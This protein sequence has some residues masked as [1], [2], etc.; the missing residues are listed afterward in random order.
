MDGCDTR[1]H[2]S[3]EHST[4]RRTLSLPFVTLI[5]LL[6]GVVALGAA[7]PGAT[8]ATRM[9]NNRQANIPHSNGPAVADNGVL[10]EWTL[11]DDGSW[12]F[13]TKWDDFRSVLWFSEGNPANTTID[14]IGQLDPAAG[15]LREWAD[16]STGG[17]VHGLTLDRSHNFWF[18]EVE[19]GK[20]GMLQPGTNSFTEWSLDPSGEPHGILVDDVISGSVTIWLGER[21]GNAISSLEPATGRYVRHFDPL[22][23]AQPHGVVLAPDHSIWFVETCGNRVGQL[24]PG[25]TDTWR[26]WQP[27]T[28][29][30][31]CSPPNHIGPLFGT[32]VGNDFWYSEPY[33]GNLIRLNPSTNTFSI[34]P[35]PN[36]TPGADQITQV[37]ADPAGNILFTEM[38]SNMVGR[39]EPSGPSVPTVVVVAPTVIEGTPPAEATAPSAVVAETPV[40]RQLTPATRVV[41]GART[42]S[43]VEWPLPTPPPTPGRQ[44]GPAR[45]EYG[46]GSLWMSEVTANKVAS[47]AVFTDTPTASPTAMATATST[48]AATNTHFAPSSTPTAPAQT[49]STATA[50]A[51]TLNFIDVPVGSTFYPYVHCLACVGIINGYPDGTFKPNNQVTRGQLSKIVSN[52]AGFSDPQTTQMFHDVPV[53]STFQVFIG[54][55]ASRGYINGYPCGGPGEPCQPGNLP[56]FRPN[57]NATRG[58]IS[59]IDSNAAGFSDPPSGQQFQDV[60]V[61]SA[62]YTYNFGLVSRDVMSGY[63]CGGAGEPCVPPGNLPYFR[64]NNNATRGQT[65][66]IVS[67]TFF[68][69]C[70]PPKR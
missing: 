37:S 13:E 19:I 15:L 65:S 39:L 58:Q 48:A 60:A 4:L 24:V 21:T 18:T 63:R 40:V 11:P 59:K 54:R 35:A 22:A 30:F 14:R 23:L 12:P 64:P 26:F 62:F 9:P 16:P 7:S 66:K 20:I 50:T 44:V 5:A 1:D 67:N 49:T 3:N 17:Y 27:P 36:P 32:F 70:S 61:G 6:V 38:Q 45:G 56:Y 52:S 41:T 69:G 33:N 29:P 42:G 28:G 10:T 57:N 25:T 2:Y 47:L 43:F 34:W 53:G 68:P 55:L 46:G 8:A 31:Q 51:C